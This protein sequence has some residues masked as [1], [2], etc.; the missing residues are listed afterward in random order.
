MLLEELDSFGIGFDE[1]FRVPVVEG[2]HELVALV[3][4]GVAGEGTAERLE[5]LHYFLLVLL[6]LLLLPL[7]HELVSHETFAHGDLWHLRR[8]LSSLDP[9]LLHSTAGIR[10]PTERLRTLLLQVP[11]QWSLLRLTKQSL[12]LRLL[13]LILLG[14]LIIWLLLLILSRLCSRLAEKARCIKFLWLF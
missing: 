1:V 6:L 4:A 9:R 12:L 2:A 5:H 8:S 7:L 14:D 11:E 13:P 3:V 10:R